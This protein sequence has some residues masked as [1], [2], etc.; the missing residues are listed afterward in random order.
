MTKRSKRNGVARLHRAVTR[1][2]ARRTRRP[3]VHDLGTIQG[4][5]GLLLDSLSHPISAEDYLVSEWLM[6]SNPFVGPDGGHG[7]DTGDGVHSHDLPEFFA[8]LSPGDRVYVAILD[9]D[10]DAITPI[11]LTRV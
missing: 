6:L 9:A 4:D 10:S 5:G 8:P 1:D 3:A 2:V 7:Q 11:V